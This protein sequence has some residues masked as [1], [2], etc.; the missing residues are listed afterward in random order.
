MSDT[1]QGKLESHASINMGG[2][3]EV[4]ALHALRHGDGRW[5][6]LCA[7]CLRGTGMA[8]S[9]LRKAVTSCTTSCQSCRSNGGRGGS[10]AMGGGEERRQRP[11]HR[12]MVGLQDLDPLPL[13]GAIGGGGVQ[14]QVQVQVRPWGIVE[15]LQAPDHRGVV[16]LRDLPPSPHQL[17]P[18]S[19]H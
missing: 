10:E 15:R 14:V 16:D 17:T 19:P 5:H 4:S 8:T 13:P 9:A 1:Y 2:G 6:G 18:S 7:V 11:D 12:G 3:G